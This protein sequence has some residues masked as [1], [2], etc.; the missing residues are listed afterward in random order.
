MRTALKIWCR[1]RLPGRLHPRATFQLREFGIRPW[2][3]RIMHNLH[4]SK[5]QREKRQPQAMEDEKLETAEPI[6]QSATLGTWEG[7]DQQ[8]KAAFEG[9]PEDIN[10][11]CIFGRLKNYPI[12]RSPRPWK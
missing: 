12:K 2:L 1:I 6:N 7:M 8:L 9:L 10:P 3:I 5:G 4:V 11:R